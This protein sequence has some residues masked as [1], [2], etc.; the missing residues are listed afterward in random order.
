MPRAPRTVARV[1]FL[2]DYIYT[3]S[4]ERR[5][6]T[7]F[8]AGHEGPVTQECAAAAIVAGAAEPLK[9]EKPHGR[10]PTSRT[11]DVPAEGG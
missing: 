7:K 9:A 8:R 2:R 5:V 1:R 4:A 11:G 10:R 6:S 3:P